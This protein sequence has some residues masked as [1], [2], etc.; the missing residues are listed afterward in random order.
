MDQTM[1][2]MKR[3]VWLI[4]LLALLPAGVAGAQSSAG[5]PPSSAWVS[6]VEQVWQINNRCSAAALTMQL[7]FYG[8]GGGY[9]DVINVLNPNPNDVSVD[10]QE[11]AA[12]ART[13]GLRAV[14]RTG[15]TIELLQRLVAAGF[16]VLVENV[17][18]DGPNGWQDWMGHNRLIVGYDDARQVLYVYDSLLGSGDG[19]GREM[20]YADFDE[21]WRPF[22]RDYMVLFEPDDQARVQ[23]AL[24]G[25]WDALFNAEATLQQV[26][27]ERETHPDGFTYFNLGSMF[28]ALGEPT[29]AADYFDQALQAGLPWRFLWYQFGV[30]EAYLLVGRHDDVLL[31]VN[32]VLANTYGVE[33][34]Y[35][36][37][38]QAHG[39][40]GE[41]DAAL[42]NYEIAASRSSRFA[43]VH[44][45]LI[46]ARSVVSGG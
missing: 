29:A 41:R 14:V 3:S 30:F 25:H 31:L 34:M 28:L 8:W 17:Y 9:Y 13:Q 5:A 24:G 18:Y 22:N 45:V 32:R 10:I 21:R 43:P 33:E 37:A 20:P 44:G 1:R 12:F 11:M 6:G 4:M 2:G 27:G 35:Y 15:G 38:G 26:W 7:S 23:D 40:R 42:R 16:P 46:G 19:R 39:A 36:Y